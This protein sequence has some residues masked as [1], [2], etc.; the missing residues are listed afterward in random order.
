RGNGFASPRPQ[1]SSRRRRRGRSY[2]GSSGR[3]PLVRVG[4]A[5]HATRRAAGGAASLGKSDQI[6]QLLLRCANAGKVDEVLPS[7]GIDRR[8]LLEGKHAGTPQHVVVD[9]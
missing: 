5:P 4:A 6:A 2:R 9:G 1:G 3:S 7:D 8:A